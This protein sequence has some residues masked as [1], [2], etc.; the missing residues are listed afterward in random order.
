MLFQP[1][2]KDVICELQLNLGKTSTHNMAA[3]NVHELSFDDIVAAIQ[4]Q[5]DELDMLK[6]LA[7]ENAEMRLR[8]EDCFFSDIPH[9]DELPTDVYHR[10]RLIDPN[11]VIAR[12]QYECPKKY[13]DAWKVLLEQHLAAG[14]LRPSLSPYTLP[15]FLIPKTDRTVLPRWVNDYRKLNSNT[16][17]DVHP[18]PSIAEIL[19]DCGNGKFFAKIDMTNS[20]FQTRVHPDD[21]PLTAVTTP[22]GLY[23]WT[24][25][26]QGCR[27]APATHQQQMFS[28]L[29]Q[30]IGSICH[31]YLDDIV[32]WSQSLEEHCRNVETVLECL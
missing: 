30:H 1:A 2:R 26:P 32:I 27:N 22:F 24:V 12:R 16:V 18:L 21:V 11:M 5:V 23:E 15:A 28:A 20:F 8:F 31:V 7:R 6:I 25:M 10:F 17:P 3:A 19:S 9:L 14:R 13:K 4:Q 29:R